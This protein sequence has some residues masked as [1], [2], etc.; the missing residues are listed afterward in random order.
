MAKQ[1]LRHGR[2]EG[3]SGS[4]ECPRYAAVPDGHAIR[5]NRR[6]YSTN[7]NAHSSKYANADA[8][9]IPGRQSHL[10]H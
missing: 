1:F 6:T 2:I 3:I 8:R 7:S 9:D 4:V 10:G 5:P